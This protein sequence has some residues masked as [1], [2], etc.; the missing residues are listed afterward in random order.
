MVTEEALGYFYLF[1]F[2]LKVKPG[3]KFGSLVGEWT[4]CSGVVIGLGSFCSMDDND[5]AEQWKKNTR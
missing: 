4:Q 5:P 2:L 1:I 3:G